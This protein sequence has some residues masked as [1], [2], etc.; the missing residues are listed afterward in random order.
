MP[1][2]RRKTIDAHSAYLE[3]VVEIRP[4]IQLLQSQISSDKG[5][6]TRKDIHNFKARHEREQT[7]DM[8]G[9]TE[10][11][12]IVKEMQNVAGSTIEIFYDENNELDGL[13]FQDGRMKTYFHHYPDLLM[14]DAT[15]SL[16][17]R[18]MPLV[19]ILVVDGNGESQIAG[20]MLIKSENVEIMD[21]LFEQFKNENP[22]HQSTEVIITDKHCTNLIVVA[23]Q[24]PQAA[25]HIC[26]FHIEQIFNREITTKK[27]SIT[28][29][30]RKH[31]LA[32]LTK[33][34]YANNQ[35]VFD[36]LYNDL[37]ASQCQRKQKFVIYFPCFISFV[38]TKLGVIDYFDEN[39]LPITEQ[40][41]KFHVTRHR[42]FGN[43]TNNRL[44][45][46]N[47]KLKAIIAKYS[48]MPTFFKLLLACIGSMTIEKD[49]HASEE[50]MRK[51]SDRTTWEPFD[52]KYSDLLTNFAFDEY[53]GEKLKCDQVQ[54]ADIDNRMGVSGIRS[55]RILTREINCD[56]FL[57]T[58]M[59]LPCRHIL[60]FRKHNNL[61]MF[62]PSICANRWYKR[63]MLVVSQLDYVLDDEA[64]VEIFRTT[65]QT[66]RPRIRNTTNQ[67]YRKADDV[68][69]D[70]C[71]RLA[72]LPQ[73]EFN[74][75]FALL[76]ELAEKIKRVSNHASSQS[77]IQTN[78]ETT[79][80]DRGNYFFL[81]NSESK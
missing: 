60:A 2:Q 37:L 23:N 17:D 47:Q 76:R 55:E 31:C 36:G 71:S 75:N 61:N 7:Q 13:L 58:S 56:C 77:V 27:R 62:D 8:I 28:T 42:I 67:K 73:R 9:L 21:N 48:A 74:E 19:I 43:R 50:L 54:F 53:M 20:L 80:A 39:W 24:F 12:K 70:I 26:V 41:V 59:G 46:L 35:T 6:V 3:K 33:M 4:R 65:S 52:I 25:H 51:Q 78:S 68:C 45:S 32:I 57:F 64:N 5:V 81:Y 38:F 79:S 14:F 18:R 15:Y 10:I 40:W 49:I 63:N 34:I 29:D 44:E 11:E 22:N 30:E 69:K 66:Q 72:E 16:N 1:K